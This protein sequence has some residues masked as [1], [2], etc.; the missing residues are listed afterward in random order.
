LGINSIRGYVISILLLCAV[1]QEGAANTFP[2]A[3]RENKQTPKITLLIFIISLG[4]LNVNYQV[5]YITY[6]KIIKE[7]N[8][9]FSGS[10]L[11]KQ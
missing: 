8:P 1:P 10:S 6:P 5:Y 11:F 3:N 9:P 4:L 2:M 7:K